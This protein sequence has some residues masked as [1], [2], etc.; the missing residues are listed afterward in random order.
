MATVKTF[1]G[2]VKGPKG[3][4]ATINGV[5]ALTVSGSGGVSASQ[6]GSTLTLSVSGTFAG[7]AVANS[8]GQSASVSLLRNSKLVSSDTNPSVNGEICWTYK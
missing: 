8:G 2:N 3:E 4:N 5:N 1:I 6:S 7:Q